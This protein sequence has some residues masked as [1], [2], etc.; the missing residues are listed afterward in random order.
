MDPAFAVGLAKVM[1][2]G[3]APELMALDRALSSRNYD[4]FGR[5]HVALTPISKATVNEYTGREIPSWK[6]L[7]LDPDRSYRLL[8][9]PA[10]LRRADAGRQ[11]SA[12][13]ERA[14]RRDGRSAAAGSRRRIARRLSAVQASARGQHDCHLDAKRDRRD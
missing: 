13:A 6:E 9:D 1:R 8:R 3:A 5:L 2:A 12:F 10:E 4:S 14:C 11:Q 7:G